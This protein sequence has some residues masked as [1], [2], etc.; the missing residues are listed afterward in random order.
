MMG[1]MWERLGRTRPMK[2]AIDAVENWFDRMSDRERLRTRPEHPPAHDQ[3]DQLVRTDPTTVLY[4]L[5]STGPWTRGGATP[6][7]CVACRN[8]HGLVLTWMSGHERLARLRCACSASW[9]DPLWAN[10]PATQHAL[11]HAHDLADE[12][13]AVD[14]YYSQEH[15]RLPIRQMRYDAADQHRRQQE[16]G[17]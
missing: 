5:V 7:T 17:D 3:A 6:A 1:P 9:C 15:L 10:A 11:T 12:D 8:Q 4:R 16:S 14:P 2:W 13:P